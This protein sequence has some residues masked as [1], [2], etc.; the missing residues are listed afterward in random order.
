MGAHAGRARLKLLLD[1]M[2]P[3]AI[4]EQLRR[5]RRDADAVTARAEL[6]MLPDPD[7]FDVAQVEGRT[8]ATENIA[9]CSAVADRYDERGRTHYGLVLVDPRSFPRGDR[10][11]IGRMVTAL[12]R[13]LVQWPDDAPTSFR[14]WL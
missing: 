5:R 7:L 14:H 9:D 1:E 4:A 8:V 2:Y 13:L 12:D 11:T 10:R 6:R 3:P